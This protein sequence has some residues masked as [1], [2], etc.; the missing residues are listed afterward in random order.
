M[1]VK[2]LRSELY[3]AT[4]TFLVSG[5]LWVRQG[6]TVVAGHPILKGRI[7]S[8]CFRPFTPTFGPVTEPEPEVA[9]SPG[10]EPS[11]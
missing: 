11:A 10:E 4:K 6:D 1:A 7:E 5:N 3:V 9:P 2:Q 8:G